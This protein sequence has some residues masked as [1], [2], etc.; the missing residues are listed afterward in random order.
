MKQQ[1]D[2]R[3]SLRKSVRSR[4]KTPPLSARDMHNYETFL[5]TFQSSAIIINLNSQQ[6]LSYIRMQH[7]NQGITKKN[8][9]NLLKVLCAITPTEDEIVR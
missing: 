6:S 2:L 8:S 7:H 9:N 4:K 5:L 3:I 1:C